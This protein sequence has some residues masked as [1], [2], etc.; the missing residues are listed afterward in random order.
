MLERYL[1]RMASIF[2]RLLTA[3]FVVFV[4]LLV[5]A[6]FVRPVLAEDQERIKKSFEITNVLSTYFLFD[7]AE[8]MVAA[9]NNLYPE[10][11]EDLKDPNYLQGFSTCEF[12]PERNFSHCD[13]YVVR[14]VAVD[15]E[16]T[17]TIGH[18]NVHGIYGADYH[19]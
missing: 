2:W 9:W 12:Y 16:N 1:A 4:V 19:Q 10:S 14:P 7:T 11:P 6:I 13:V 15:G 3:S 18:E 17:L 5:T 8:E